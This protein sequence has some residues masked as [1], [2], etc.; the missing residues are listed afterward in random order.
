[1]TQRTA[2]VESTRSKSAVP[3]IDKLSAPTIRALHRLGGS[4]S[5]TELLDAIIEDLKL[6]EAITQIP[7]GRGSKTELEYRAAWA[8]TY[9]KNACL[10]ENS[11]R[12]VWALTP[13]GLRSPLVDA[14]KLVRDRRE[15]RRQRREARSARAKQLEGLADDPQEPEPRT[16]REDLL[17]RLLAMDPI[18]FERLCQRLL[19]E[20]GFIEV[21]V[22]RRSSDGGIDGY[23]TIR[24]GGLISFNVLFQ[25]KRYQGSLGPDVV[26][27]FRGARVGRADKGVIIT[28]GSFTREARKEATRDGA[29]PIDLIDGELLVDKLKELG[30]G[31]R[32]RMVEQVEVDQE[33]FGLI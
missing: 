16:W 1:M 23:G 15:R 21:E 12:A 24:I 11:D 6:P 9:L 22:T 28:T 20:A 31:V 7:H 13:E 18:A 10:I 17:D 4:A 26:R 19:R 25:S 2:A 3:G 14:E 5:I 29:P 8:R 32:T 27:D 30:L 33:W